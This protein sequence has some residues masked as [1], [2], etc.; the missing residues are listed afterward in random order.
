MVGIAVDDTGNVY[1]VD[2]GNNR[3]RRISAAGIVVTVAG[4]G[5]LPGFAGDG[6]PASK[7]LLYE[8][9]DVALDAAG[10]LYIADTG[11]NRIRK[12]D[13]QGIISTIAGTGEAASTGDGAAATKA[14]VNTPDSVAI[15]ADGTL[16]VSEPSRIRR[17]R[18][19]G[20]IQTVAGNGM[21]HVGQPPWTVDSF[22][23]EGGPATA[24]RFTDASDMRLGPDGNLY[25][26]D[27]LDCRV[28]MI[29]AAGLIHT[30][31]GTGCASFNGTSSGD[32]GKAVAAELARP[33]DVAFGPDK[34]LYILEHYGGVRVVDQSGGISTLKMAWRYEEALGMAI[35]GDELYITDRDHMAIIRLKLPPAA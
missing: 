21:A 11:N 22:A 2:Q 29:D 15:A 10:N 26:A 20:I 7:A 24:A 6:G 8:P 32:G 13:R 12:V 18:P 3:V 28:L 4:S 23:G 31:A 25:F 14:A 34:R 9:E 35:T 19:D 17:I 33:V 27:F 30:V 16:Y 5:N 1:V